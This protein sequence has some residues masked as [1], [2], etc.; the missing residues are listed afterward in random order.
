MGRGRTLIGRADGPA[1][2][3]GTAEDAALE[4]FHERATA[5]VW[6]PMPLIHRWS[7]GDRER[8]IAELKRLDE[9]R[10]RDSAGAV[11]FASRRTDEQFS[12]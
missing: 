6:A 3:P 11:E 1:P 5:G 4:Y 12:E 2:G 9:Q 7:A 10:E 8:F